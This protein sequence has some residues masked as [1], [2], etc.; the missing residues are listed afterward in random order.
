MRPTLALTAHSL[1]RFSPL[2]LLM[3]VVLFVFQV[4]AVIMA[5]TF[6]ELGTFERITALIPPFIRQFLGSS[7]LGVFTFP[8]IACVGY[9]HVA[10]MDLWRSADEFILIEA[11]RE[12]AKTTLARFA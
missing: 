1:R 3:T 5:S 10:I 12:G 4:L 7:L 11:F 6:Q 9:F 2:L 8:G